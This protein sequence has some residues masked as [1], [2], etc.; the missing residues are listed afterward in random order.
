MARLHPCHPLFVIPYRRVLTVLASI[1]DHK[2]RATA[3]PDP[4][5]PPTLRPTSSIAR[6]SSEQSTEANHFLW[7]LQTPAE[8]VTTA[9]QELTCGFCDHTII[10]PSLPPSIPPS[11]SPS[12]LPLPTLFAGGEYFAS[13]EHSSRSISRVQSH[14]KKKT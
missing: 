12:S 5:H 7:E 3:R 6:I 10:P 9:E 8:R 4:P 14:T 1:G 13:A 2:Q 11:L